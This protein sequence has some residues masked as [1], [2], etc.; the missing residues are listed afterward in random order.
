MPRKQL[1]ML[2]ICEVCMT[3]QWTGW[4]AVVSMYCALSNKV[5]VFVFVFDQDVG[6]VT[7]DGSDG[8]TV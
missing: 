6:D 7:K 2:L 1:R 4:E 3:A 5:F 8:R